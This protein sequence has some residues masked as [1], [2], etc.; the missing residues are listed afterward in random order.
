MVYV[1]GRDTIAMMVVPYGKHTT[2]NVGIVLLELNATD[3]GRCPAVIEIL[4]VQIVVVVTCCRHDVN[5]TIGDRNQLI[6]LLLHV[7]GLGIGIVPDVHDYVLA[8]YRGL[9][10][11]VCQCTPYHSLLAKALNEADI[12]IGELTELLHYLLIAIAVLVGTDIYTLATEYRVLAFEVFTEYAIDEGIGLGVEHIQV[13]HAILLAAQLGLVVNESKAVCGNVD[14]GNYL[15][16]VVLAQD[17]QVDELL[18]GVMTILR[19]QTRMQ[20][21][22]QTEA[23]GSLVPII[24]KELTE[25]VVV[26]VNLKCIHLVVCHHLNKVVEIV[27]GH[28]LTANVHHETTQLINRHV[29]CLTLGESGMLL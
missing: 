12:V 8:L 1:V 21:A 6:A 15:H 5:K 2:E 25:T 17:L 13:I 27:D 29:H 26:E 10:I 28:E 20:C 18:L 9:A 23:R 16:V 22:L 4:A 11:S 24:A 7:L 19:G 14:F 3:V